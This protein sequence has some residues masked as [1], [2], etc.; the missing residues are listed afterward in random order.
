[1]G[2][3]EILKSCKKQK[4][5]TQVNIYLGHSFT[6]HLYFSVKDICDNKVA[7]SYNKKLLLHTVVI[8]LI[9]LSPF[10]VNKSN[11]LSL[12]NNLKLIII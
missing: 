3:K 4:K 10:G 2:L 12:T 6:F 9:F 1:M 5:Q 11:I 8:K 7:E